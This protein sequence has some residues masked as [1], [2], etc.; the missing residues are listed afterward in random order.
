M[1]SAGLMG[2]FFI[3]IQEIWIRWDNKSRRLSRNDSFDYSRLSRN[4]GPGAPL[5]FPQQQK[6]LRALPEPSSA[7]EPRSGWGE[8]RFCS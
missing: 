8:E 7:P 4:A 3:N 5:P 2:I 6:L 1:A